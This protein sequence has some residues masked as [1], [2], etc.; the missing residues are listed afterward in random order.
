M[1]QPDIGPRNLLKSG[2][3]SPPEF[4]PTKV[5]GD[6]SV[7][8]TII[9]PWSRSRWW[10]GSLLALIVALAATVPT[11]GDL[12]LTWDEPVYRLSQNRSAQWWE[13]LFQARS[14]NDL[15]ALVEPDALLFY[16]TYGRHGTNFHPPLAGQLNLLTY[17]I[18]GRW[19]KD[20]PARRMASILE[21]TLTIALAFGFLSRRYGA[22]VGGI[23]ASAL[24]FMPRVYG[25]AH[26]A[27]TDTPGLLLWVAATLAFW[28]GLYQPGARR[29]RVAVGVLL[30]LAFVEKMAAVFVL[31]PLLG[32]LILVHLPLAFRGPGRRAN[33]IDGLVTSSA[34]LAPLVVALIEIVRLT[35]H[36]PVPKMTDLFFDRP[37]SRIPGVI[38]AVPLGVW[39]LRRLMERVFRNSAVW[40]VER[41]ALEIWTSILAFAPVVGWLGNPAW[42]RETLPR[43]AHYAMLN[44]DRR[45]SL[46]D[47]SILYMGRIYEF[48]L[49]WHNGW[50]LLAITVPTTLLAASF[51]G[52]LYSLFRGQGDRL[53][54]FFLLNLCALPAIRMLPTPAHDGVRLMLPSFFYLAAMVG[55]GTVAVADMLAKLMRARSPMLSRSLFSAAVLIPAAWQ[56]VKIHPYELS[57]YNEWV[58]GPRGAWRSGF[59]LSYW[60]DA[61][62]PKT[63]E[64][65]NQRLPEGVRVDFLNDRSNPMSFFE[66]QSLG[67]LRSDLVLGWRDFEQF[68]YVWLLTQDSKASGFTRLLF[69]MTPWFGETPPQLDGARVVTVADPIAASRAWALR[70]LAESPRDQQTERPIAPVW[71]HKY[72][73]FLGRFWGEGLIH[74]PLKSLNNA[75]FDWARSD[76]EGLRTAARKLARQGRADDDP[77]ARRLMDYLTRRQEG[78]FA[79]SSRTM[80]RFRPESLLDAVEILIKRPDAVRSVL[81]R[82]AYTDPDTI[83]GTLDRDL[84]H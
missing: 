83:G 42:W 67:A 53:P 59:E 49:P 4:S 34:M 54:L 18:F 80:L 43:L 48:S 1:D 72:A 21:Y 82:E 7:E 26:V 19:M 77:D 38:L 64:K 56:L 13:R 52:V 51:S 27:A 35:K 45:G 14:A 71:V 65:I 15:R 2:D 12:G 39:V 61:F 32:W 36:L 29:W 69:V 63:I 24:L 5:A 23:A 60:Y 47:I 74:M 31:G 8:T 22:W 25:D 37:S 76:P 79:M 28:K 11:A 57:Y 58:G 6:L 75:V 50:V 40:G 73:P 16:W 55:W 62:T 70:A 44:T 81:E 30:G 9:S 41:P 20:T 68:R 33:W 10:L 46:P 66:L 3:L 84:P 78:I 17:E